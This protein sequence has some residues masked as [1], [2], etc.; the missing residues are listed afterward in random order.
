MKI[1]VTGSEGFIG[2]NLCSSL[3]LRSDIELLTFTR[4]Q[5]LEELADL[6]LEADFIY[7]IAGVNR[8]KDEKEFQKGNLALTEY[9]V[10]TLRTS[11][12]STPILITSSTQAE[13]DNPYGESKQAAEQTLRLW[14]RESGASVYIYRLPG[15]FGKWCRPNYNSV[16]ATFCHN[17]ANDLPVTISD[18]SHIITL[19]YI[20]DVI[21]AF[22][23]HLDSKD[24][25]ASASYQTIDRIFKVS[26]GELDD[27]IR[28]I[29]NIRTSLLV[30]DLNDM[31]NKFLYATYISYLDTDN[32][33]YSLTKNTD[34]RGF[35]TEFIKSRHF[36]Q[37]FVSQTKPG[38]T[39]GDHWHKTKIEKFFVVA[40]K[41]EVTFRNK[42]NTHDIIRYTV[43]GDE[44]R[45]I[46][47]PTGYVH[48]IKNIG[49]TELIT[50]FWAN[51]LLDKENPDTYYEKVEETI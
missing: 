48:A 49:D 7:H 3:E 28:T 16:V 13:L 46:D 32:F 24:T 8:P 17:I 29:H 1:L 33:S 19:V 43:E 2:K 15:V 45:V 50:L 36:G 37:I 47:I 40:G 25:A 30:P 26:L 20:D 22:L 10:D 14:S 4:H 35:L 21:S 41:A 23:G 51:E 38:I 5:S 18:P 39:R 31:L 6:T 42:V 34:E 44:M 9:I 27:R 11:G 12:K